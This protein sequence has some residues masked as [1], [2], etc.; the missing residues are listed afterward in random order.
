MQDEDGLTFDQW[1][2]AQGYADEHRAILAETWNAALDSAKLEI[3]DCYAW[4]LEEL[5]A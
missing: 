4:T 5:K 1:F 2:A 3:D